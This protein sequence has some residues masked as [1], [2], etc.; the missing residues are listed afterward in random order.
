METTCRTEE[1]VCSALHD[2]DNDIE[3]ACDMLLEDAD[4]TQ[5][6]IIK[7]LGLFNSASV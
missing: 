3:K 7:F 6:N 5:V 4:Q 1:E 2:C